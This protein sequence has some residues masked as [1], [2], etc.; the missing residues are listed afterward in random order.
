MK[1]QTKPAKPSKQ[2]ARRFAFISLPLLALALSA[3]AQDGMVPARSPSQS[4]YG[5]L[6]MTQV[7]SSE[8]MGQGIMNLNLRAKFH[9]Q[10]DAVPGVAANTQITAV[11]GGAALG[12][13]SYMDVFVGMNIYNFNGDAGSNSGFGSVTLG[14]KGTLP[15]AKG[16]PLRMG[17]QMAGIWGTGNNQFNTYRVDGYNYLESRSDKHSDL[18]VR[19]T[20][21][22]L[23]TNEDNGGTGFNLHF[24]EGVIA[25]FESGKGVAVV[26]GA[27][28]EIIPISQF[29]L[30]LE[31]NFRSLLSDVSMSDPLWVTPS[32]TWRTPKRVNVN[33]GVDVSLSSERDAPEPAALAPWRLF[34]G[35]SGSIDTQRSKKEAG[36]VKAREAREA[37]ARARRDSVE[38]VSLHRQAAS[39]SAREKATADSLAALKNRSKQDSAAMAAKARQD[40]LALADAATKLALEKSKRSDAEKQLL[41]TGL[42]LMDAVYFETGKTDI[43]INSKPYLNIIAKMLVKYPKLQIQVSGHTDNVG[44]ADY[45]MGLSQGRAEAVRVY[46]VS[47]APELGNHL[48]AKGYGMTSPKATNS[49]AAGRTMNRRTELQVLNKDALREYNQ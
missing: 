27:G 22:L 3:H 28:V 9:E 11:S 41:S 8:A 34:G 38:N 47:V 24:N 25:S 21:S 7:T 1:T 10:G 12:V 32:V 15:A 39:S 29:I 37:A 17:L 13:N 26:A 4:P 19:V 30:G 46:M 40:S 48:T 14:A 31:G 44:G 2:R 36:A 45:N 35:I 49:T 18:L 6:G 43:S 23:M 20:Q 42:L 16:A 33:L 5:V